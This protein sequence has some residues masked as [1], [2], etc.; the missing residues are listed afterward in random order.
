MAL[1]KF[2]EFINEW[3]DSPTPPDDDRRF[4]EPD[5]SGEWSVLA[6]D[7][8]EHAVAQ[9]DGKKYLVY[10]GHL[11]KKDLEDFASREIESEQ[12][13][14]G[15][16][17]TYSDDWDIDADVIQGWLNSKETVS[18]GKGLDDWESG[19]FDA[20]EATPEVVDDVRS[21]IAKYGKSAADRRFASA[22]D[23]LF[24]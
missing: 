18:I 2:N 13:E 17:D 22:L 10:F 20:V 23:E 3:W 5:V 11:S 16:N 4:T 6:I 7:S 14:D 15:W 9:R 21:L 12:D 8:G 19:D 24:A 1:K